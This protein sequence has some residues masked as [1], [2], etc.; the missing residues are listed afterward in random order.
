[1]NKLLVALAALL[2]LAG[3]SSSNSSSSGDSQKLVVAATAVPH[4]EI[5]KQVKPLLAKE[6]VDLEIKVF[7]DY[8]QPNTQVAEKAI[9]LNYFQTKPYLDEFNRQRGTHLTIV[10]GVHIEPFGAYSRKLK[11]IDQLPEGASVT[12]P[13]DPSNNSRALLLLARHGLITLKDPNNELSTQKDITANPKNLKFRELE[14]AM[15]P[16]TLDEVD[17]ALINTNYALAAGLNPTRDALLIEGKDSPYVNYL[18]GR[19][20]NKDDPRVQKLA[21]A[22]TSP[23]VKAF[24]EQK[25]QGAVLPAF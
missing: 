24:I 12:L 17:L 13:N 10:T 6:G 5:L 16:R 20:D 1:M 18:V 14:A 8:V 19:P 9:D 4:A 23:E 11:S 25:Y 7:A 2:A 21:K 22:L 15:L 3:C